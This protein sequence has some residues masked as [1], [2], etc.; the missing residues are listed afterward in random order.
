MAGDPAKMANKPKASATKEP[1]G[2]GKGW[3]VTTLELPGLPRNE[4]YFYKESD[5]DIYLLKQMKLV[6]AR[7]AKLAR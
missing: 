3:I 5:A 6:E 7:N 4:Q 2:R 1:F